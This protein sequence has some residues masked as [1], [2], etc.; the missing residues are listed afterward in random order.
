[1]DFKVW[2]MND[3]VQFIKRIVEETNSKRNNVHAQWMCK[4]DL[5][6]LKWAIDQALADCE[7]Y[8][9]EEE[10]IKSHERRQFLKKIENS[11]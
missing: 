3:M 6:K 4:Q 2:S 1:M 7:K 5:Y 8:P 10:F 9:K 11:K